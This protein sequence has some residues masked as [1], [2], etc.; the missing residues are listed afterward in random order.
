MYYDCAVI[1]AQHVATESI[2]KSQEHLD[3]ISRI[4][5]SLAADVSKDERLK[6]SLQEYNEVFNIVAVRFM[7]SYIGF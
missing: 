4:I 7:S 1:E 6:T 3:I 5:T 2:K